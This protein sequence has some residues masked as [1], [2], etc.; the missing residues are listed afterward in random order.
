MS[1]TL[2]RSLQFAQTY[3]SIRPLLGV[4][5]YTDE[6][7]LTIGDWVRQF[8]LAPPFSWRWNRGTT[9]FNVSPAGGQDYVRSLTDFGW[10][11]KANLTS[12]GTNRELAVRLNISQDTTQEQPIAICPLLDDGAGNITFRM[13][14]TPDAAYTVKLIYQ[15]KAV[16]F[17]ASTD[18]WTPI[19]DY[20]SYLYNQG[21][22]AKAYE[23][24]SDERF[25][26]AT[27][28][29]L[30]QVIAANEGLTESQKNVFMIDQAITQRE[31]V[32][33]QGKS[34]ASTAARGMF[35]G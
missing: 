1:I 9:S 31:I 23:M 8:I 27:Q 19:P 24:S 20:L 32:E 33:I 28:L 2:A 7:G 3:I 16:A 4:G 5:T 34:Q 15:K 14:P 10:L 12:A 17:T 11:E 13:M 18:T 30:R 6:P 22:L 21:V 35:G 29:F 26:L 25:G